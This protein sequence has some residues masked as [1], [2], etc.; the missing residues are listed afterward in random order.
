MKA[1]RIKI[2]YIKSWED[3]SMLYFQQII[4]DKNVKRSGAISKM[5][6]ESIEYD[7]QN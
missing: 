3:I 6:I 4:N 7:E 2:I 5:H 1:V